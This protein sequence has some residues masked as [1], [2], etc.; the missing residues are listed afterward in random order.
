MTYFNTIFLKNIDIWGFT[1]TYIVLYEH[2]Y[3]SFNK[4][5]NYQI[6]FINKLKYIII[7]F[8]YENPIEPINISSLIQ[9]L[10][11]LNPILEKMDKIGGNLKTKRYKKQLKDGNKKDGNNKTKKRHVIAK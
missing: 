1:M 8:L 3:D 7:H 10:T 5:S 9:E 11:N 2:L 4:L 6:Q